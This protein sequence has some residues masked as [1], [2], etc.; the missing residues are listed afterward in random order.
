MP[1]VGPPQD[2][3]NPTEKV[4]PLWSKFVI[5]ELGRGIMA[6]EE[7]LEI[8]AFMLKD[9]HAVFA[10]SFWGSVQFKEDLWGAGGPGARKVTV[11][12]VDAILS[13][14]HW[15]TSERKEIQTSVVI[16]D[17]QEGKD[18][19]EGEDIIHLLI[20]EHEWNRLIYLCERISRWPDSYL[21]RERATSRICFG[22]QNVYSW[23]VPS[24]LSFSRN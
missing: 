9:A 3:E 12:K 21:F 23:D 6:G 15:W 16:R 2:R 4:I 10:L 5:V 8:H 13:I 18:Q 1:W 22:Q 24:V 17:V 7:V 19:P 14:L 20:K 11:C